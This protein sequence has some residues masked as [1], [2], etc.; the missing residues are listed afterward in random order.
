[1]ASLLDVATGGADSP[2]I[3]A[4]MAQQAGYQLRP[5]ASDR[6]LDALVLARARMAMARTPLMASLLLHDALHAPCADQSFDFTTCILALHH[7]TPDEAALLFQELA[8]ITRHAAI[9]VDLRRTWVGYLGARLLACGP[10]GSM[11]RHDGPLS[12]LRAYTP[13]EVREIASIAGVQAEVQSGGPF[14]MR[15][16]INHVSM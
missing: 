14:L 10:W 8:R 4:E 9:V 12:V 3:L 7:F 6:L 11:A 13:A 16:V 2:R 15:I 5:F 1:M